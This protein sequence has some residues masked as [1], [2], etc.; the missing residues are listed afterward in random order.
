MEMFNAVW[1]NTFTNLDWVSEHPWLE[2]AV[3][4]TLYTFGV[5]YD[6]VTD[7]PT[8]AVASP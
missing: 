1:G 7:V 8:P 4:I 3:S 5:L 6:F 2:F